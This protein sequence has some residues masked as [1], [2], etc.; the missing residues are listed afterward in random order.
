[1]ALGIALAETAAADSR[2]QS[3]AHDSLTSLLF[4]EKQYKKNRQAAQRKKML[5]DRD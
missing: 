3:G 5:Y 2:S 1:M 4:R